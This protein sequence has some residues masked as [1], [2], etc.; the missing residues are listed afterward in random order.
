M[1][2]KWKITGIAVLYT[3]VFLTCT[4][5]NERNSNTGLPSGMTAP[6][7]QPEQSVTLPEPTGAV[8]EP[9]NTPTTEPTKAPDPTENPVSPTEAVKTTTL[10]EGESV[11]GYIEAIRSW[12]NYAAWNYPERWSL[13]ET[14]ATIEVYIAHNIDLKDVFHPGIEHPY[15][16]KEPQVFVRIEESGREPYWV[17]SFPNPNSTEGTSFDL[18]TSASP[19]RRGDYREPKSLDSL[20][21]NMYLYERREIVFAK[22]EPAYFADN[23]D[24]YYADMT[25][26]PVYKAIR[27]YALYNDCTRLVEGLRDIKIF[28]PKIDLT[29]YSYGYVG[30]VLDDTYYTKCLVRMEGRWERDYDFNTFS[31][32]F[33][34]ADEDLHLL[35]E[36]EAELERLAANAAEMIHVRVYYWKENE[37]MEDLLEKYPYTKEEVFDLNRGQY[38]RI[39]HINGRPHSC[40]VLL[41]AAEE[42]IPEPTVTPTPELPSDNVQL[43]QEHFCDENFRNYLSLAIDENKDGIL[44]L[45]EREKPGNDKSAI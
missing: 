17:N 8:E 12:R 7:T 15:I 5:C 20:R 14:K 38:K 42:P 34:N 39:E 22:A 28:L 37:T 29:R 3:A 45:K 4:A 23:P 40:Y 1:K 33:W 41:P 16:L 19:R 2:N 24:K 13:E 30:Y 10:P 36:K 6:A 9:T 21:E 44:T 11:D 18:T 27:D 35:S 43:D 32:P 26:L 25:D 31:S